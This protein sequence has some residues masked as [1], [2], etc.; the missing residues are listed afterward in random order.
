MPLSDR[1]I[2]DDLCSVIEPARMLISIDHKLA[3]PEA[4]DVELWSEL[5]ALFAEPQ[6]GSA[7][8]AWLFLTDVALQRNWEL[9]TRLPTLLHVL[10]IH[11]DHR[12]PQVRCRAQRMLFRLIRSWIP[13]SHPTARDALHQ[14]EQEAKS[15]YWKEDEPEADLEPKLKW[16]CTRISGLMDPLFPSLTE[17]RGSV[18]LNWGPSCSIRPIAFRL[19]QVFRPQPFWGTCACLSTTVEGEFLQVVTSTCTIKLNID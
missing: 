2:F 18:A 17:S 4:Q 19:L 16:F 14:L 13:R 12:N 10:V 1:G 5:D 3:F 7:Q 11:L 6:L 15:R 8:F 9:K